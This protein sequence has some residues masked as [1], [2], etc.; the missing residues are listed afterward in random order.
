MIDLLEEHKDLFVDAT[1][2]LIHNDL[3]LRNILVDPQTKEITGL[4]DMEGSRGFD[5]LKDA[6]HLLKYPLQDNQEFRHYRK[7]YNLPEELN[8]E[9]RLKTLVYMGV[10]KM[11]VA[12]FYLMREMPAEMKMSQDH[13]QLILDEL[14][15]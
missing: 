7:G 2:S 8:S 9:E 3:H 1:C 10:E 12:T 6:K 14:R 15:K 11:G 4:L 13:L 5:P